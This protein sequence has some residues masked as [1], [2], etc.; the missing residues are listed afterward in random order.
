[1]GFLT[2]KERLTIPT[3]DNPA[4]CRTGTVVIDEEKCNGCG[5]C[6]LICPA[7]CIY[8]AGEGKNKKVR[9]VNEDFPECFSCNDCAA[10]CKRGAITAKHGYD[11]GGRFKAIR[12]GELCP[13]RNF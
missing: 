2:W 1:M 4:T 6:V 11:F 10:I 3:Y 8:I 5:M 13:P 7:A 12:R 9:L